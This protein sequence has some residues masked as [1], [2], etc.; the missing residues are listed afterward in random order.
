M[1]I[2]SKFVSNSSSCSFVVSLEEFPTT[3]DLAEYML[4]VRMADIRVD[5][6]A[7]TGVAHL[8]NK[9]LKEVEKKH[10]KRIRNLHNFANIKGNP[11]SPNIAFSSCNFDTFITQIEVKDKKYLY[12][13]TCNNTQWDVPQVIPQEE[14]GYEIEHFSDGDLYDGVFDDFFIRGKSYFNLETAGI[15]SVKNLD[16]QLSVLRN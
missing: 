10:S 7:D 12:V 16:D 15:V 11:K 8:G 13:S 9:T 3:V 6:G 2:R 1:K 14:T 5:T 4:E